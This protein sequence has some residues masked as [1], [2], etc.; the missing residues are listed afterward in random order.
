[1]LF[2]S[3]KQPS[4]VSTYVVQRGDTLN[5]IAAQP[6]V[7]NDAKKWTLLYENNRDALDNPMAIYPGQ[8]L[9]VIP[10]N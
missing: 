6:T 9:K 3:L 10:E 7:Y 8:V 1:M 2:R 4:T 5:S